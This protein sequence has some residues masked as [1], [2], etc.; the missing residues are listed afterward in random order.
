MKL[1]IESRQRL[2][3][4]GSGARYSQTKF[5]HPMEPERN[6]R[7][8]QR[9]KELRNTN[10]N[11]RAVADDLAHGCLEWL[12]GLDEHNTRA[13]R[14]WS[15]NAHGQHEA[16]EHRKQEGEPIILG[17]LKRLDTTVH[18]GRDVGMREHRALGFAR[19]AR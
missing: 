10:E 7:V 11:R 6:L 1:S 8:R 15:E 19:C 12:D 4:Q 13:H 3:R 9:L 5:Q 18:V 2:T 17:S 16:M 14:Q